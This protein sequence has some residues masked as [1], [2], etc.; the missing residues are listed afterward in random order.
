MAC[1]LWPFQHLPALPTQGTLG[2][3]NEQMRPLLGAGQVVWRQS[4]GP[5]VA[6][7]GPGTASPR[8]DLLAGWWGQAGCGDMT[9]GDEGWGVGPACWLSREGSGSHPHLGRPP[10]GELG[11]AGG[12]GDK[13]WLGGRL[14]T[15][16][17]LPPP[18]PSS[19]RDQLLSLSLQGQPTCLPPTFRETQGSEGQGSHAPGP[20]RSQAAC[21]TA[22]PTT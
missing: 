15:A 11:P 13:P 1:A 10:S 7:A 22:F 20:G 2:K 9:D 8:G 12:S 4:P 17:T 21:P 18:H 6:L 19:P 16:D 14:P 5:E 3:N